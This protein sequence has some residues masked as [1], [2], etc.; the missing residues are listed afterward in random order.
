M[1]PAAESDTTEVVLDVDA[2]KERQELEAK[3]KDDER[4]FYSCIFFFVKSYNQ[5]S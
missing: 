5:S 2:E 1:E 3:I 4:V